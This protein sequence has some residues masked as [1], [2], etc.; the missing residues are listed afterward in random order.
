MRWAAGLRPHG[1]RD[2]A[3]RGRR[4]QTSGVSPI[5]AALVAMAMAASSGGCTVLALG[6]GA[7][8]PRLR[9]VPP[10]GAQ[11][12]PG[13]DVSLVLEDGR[14]VNGRLMWQSSDAIAVGSDVVPMANVVAV[15]ER[16]GN[17]AETGLFVGLAID[18]AVVLGFAVLVSQIPRD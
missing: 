7:A 5:V 15:R 9:D 12:A 18:V 13:S 4:W 14:M 11:L 6:I 17:H 8:T 3:D 10:G 2:G 1:D 16:T